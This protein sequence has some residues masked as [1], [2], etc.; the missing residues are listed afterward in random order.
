[1]GNC[2]SKLVERY[3]MVPSW[4][5]RL[6]VETGHLIPVREV[7]PGNLGK[8]EGRFGVGKMMQFLY[9]CS[10]SQKNEDLIVE[11]GRRLGLLEHRERYKIVILESRNGNL[12]GETLV[13]NVTCNQASMFCNQASMMFSLALSAAWVWLYPGLRLSGDNIGS[14]GDRCR[15]IVCPHKEM[16]ITM[17]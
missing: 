9:N 8:D 12:L 16:I 5:S 2:R 1:M 15:R 11:V 4:R 17:K 6:Q 7:N 14:V 10:F 3:G 13:I